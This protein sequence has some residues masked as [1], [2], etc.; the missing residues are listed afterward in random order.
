[1][2]RLHNNSKYIGPAQAVIDPV[3]RGAGI[4]GIL[5]VAQRVNDCLSNEPEQKG[6]RQMSPA[7]FRS[8]GKI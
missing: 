5:L 1:M 3:N 7:F 4:I 2:D 8:P 6:R